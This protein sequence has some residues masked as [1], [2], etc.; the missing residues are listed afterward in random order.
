MRTLNVRN[1]NQALPQALR[2]LRAEGE[3]RESRYGP[4]LVHPRPVATDYE[5]PEERVVFWADRDAN[6]F[7]HLFEGI[8]MLAGRNDVAPLLRFNSRMAEFSDDGVTLH[9]AYGKRWYSHFGVDQLEA[10]LSVLKQ[11]PDD[12]RQI[13]QIWDPV[14]DLGRAGKDLPCNQ[15]VHFTRNARGALDA[16]VFCRS[17]D[18]VWGTYGSDAVC[19]SML[20]EYAARSSGF[21]VGRY[22]QVSS[23]WHGYLA[24]VEPL[25]PLEGVLEKAL[26]PYESKDATPYLFP[27]VST[28]RATWKRDANMLLTE[29]S[30]AMGYTDPFFRKVALPLLQA[31]EVYKTDS[32]SRH[33]DATELARCCIAG[34]WRDAAIQWI[35]RRILKCRARSRKS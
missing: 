7:F 1:V 3:R 35:E 21:P 9:G 5:R 28:D 25:T 8:W 30:R 20:L 23:N 11:N 15:S 12:R 14:A 22:C 17:N 32:R 4:V 18:A 31:W 34:D 16:T 6:P 19:F 27:L 33:Q 2:L 29:G 13:L 10:I 24:T 26:D